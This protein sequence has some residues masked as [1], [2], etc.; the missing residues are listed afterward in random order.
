MST[1]ESC[2]TCQHCFAGQTSA[3]SWCR[4]R[5]LTFDLA[6]AQFGLCHHWTEKAPSLPNLSQDNSEGFLEKQLEFGRNFVG[7]IEKDF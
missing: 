1:K 7:N 6:L 5:K 3:H 2:R 4:L